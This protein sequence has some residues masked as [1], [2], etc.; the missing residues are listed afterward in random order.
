MTLAQRVHHGDHGLDTVALIGSRLVAFIVEA[1]A[2]I[3]M[4]VHREIVQV[5]LVLWVTTT[6]VLAAS[7]VPVDRSTSS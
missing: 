3:S 5:P 2:A 4:V 6:S 1:L 7:L